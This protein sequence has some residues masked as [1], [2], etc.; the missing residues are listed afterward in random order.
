MWL[1]SLFKKIN[2]Y[3]FS[4]LYFKLL[5]IN[6]DR[7]LWTY[8]YRKKLFLREVS[9][10]AT[11][12]AD[13]HFVNTTCCFTYYILHVILAQDSWSHG[14][15]TFTRAPRYIYQ[16]RLF[17]FTVFLFILLAFE[18][19]DSWIGGTDVVVEN[20]FVWTGSGQTFTY[21][22]WGP[23]NPD[24]SGGNQHCVILYQPS[25]YKWHDTQCTNTNSYICEK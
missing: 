15:V 16:L 9:K 8:I 20:T 14:M 19:R 23:G 11:W 4:I 5:R 10:K 3:L 24:N 7:Y 21:I 6:R 12:S 17:F 2:I 22:N 18:T 13:I 1:L 25:D